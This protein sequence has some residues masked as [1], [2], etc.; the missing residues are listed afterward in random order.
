MRQFTEASAKVTAELLSNAA[1]AQIVEM[2]GPYDHLVPVHDA[3]CVVLRLTP[4]S[5]DVRACYPDRWGE[6]RFERVGD[7][8]VIPPG[9]VMHVRSE[10]GRTTGISCRFDPLLLSKWFDD[11]LEWTQWRL[12]AGLAVHDESIRHHMNRLA[13]EVRH[14]GFAS[15]TLL[16]LIAS[17]LVIELRRHRD[18]V[19]RD[20]GKS[21]LAKW[22]LLLID[23][24][25]RELGKAPSLS[26]IANLCGLSVRQLSRGFRASRLCSIGHY[27]E[28]SRIENAKRLLLSG[29]CAKAVAYTM[30]FS[31]PSSFSYAF[32]RATGMSPSRFQAALSEGEERMRSEVSGASPAEPSAEPISPGAAA[33]VP[34]TTRRRS[35]SHH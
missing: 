3:F 6:H 15:E 17:Q 28:A 4:G 16:E 26:E 11:D 29:Q 10:I 33:L 18:S 25:V 32:H 24:R 9:E 2:L 5:H 31:S 8:F 21:G 1:R 20:S 14:P 19:D 30:G 23:D 27:I 7:L 35:F 22:R 34:G 12:E 13:R